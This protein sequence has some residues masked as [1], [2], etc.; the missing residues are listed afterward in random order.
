MPT[1][2]IPR[3]AVKT[4]TISAPSGSF[5]AGLVSATPFPPA[6]R[7]TDPISAYG[8]PMVTKVPRPIVELGDMT[9][10]F[11]DEGQAFSAISSAVVTLSMSTEYWNGTDT[12]TRSVSRDVSVVS[13]APGNEVAVDGERK[14]TI[15]VMV[16]PIG[17]DSA[18]T[19][20]D[21]PGAAS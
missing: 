11:L 20:A 8:D 14:A 3:K 10:T 17:G 19:S 15:V 2:S 9:L 1:Q 4:I 13:V 7:N 18:A 5:A 6:T 21:V 12:A 16:T